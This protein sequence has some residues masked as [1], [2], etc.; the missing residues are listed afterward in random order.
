MDVAE[1]VDRDGIEQRGGQHQVVTSGD[2]P[3]HGFG[4]RANA[5]AARLMIAMRALSGV[6][7]SPQ[8]MPITYELAS[9]QRV[10][11]PTHKSLVKDIDESYL[12]TVGVDYEALAPDCV[13][14]SF[15]D[16]IDADPDGAIRC[17]CIGAIRNG[18]TTFATLSLGSA[19]VLA[20]DN[21]DWYLFC[22]NTY[23][24]TSSLR[25]GLVDVRVVCQNTHRRALA[26]KNARL[27]SV[28]HTK[29]A[30]V[31][32]ASAVDAIGAIRSEMAATRAKYQTLAGA[33][34]NGDKLDKLV[35][36]LFPVPRKE[37]AAKVAEVV[38]AAAAVDGAD[39]LDSILSATELATATVDDLID[40][41]MDAQA[42]AKR[43]ITELYE[44]KA[45]GADIPGVAGTA[46]GAYNAVTEYITHHRGRTDESRF[47]SAAMGPDT[48]RALTAVLELIKVAA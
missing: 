12:A 25:F 5:D 11:V 27:F 41:Q 34:F 4:R 40:A 7:W 13:D 33:S 10:V 37:D 20:G 36:K 44:G 35:T 39:L 9:G 30:R 45:I 16:I 8:D 32:L 28:R 21:V 24:G 46:W 38:K 15:Q 2:A 48:D 17:D 18:R 31:K 26:S 1:M 19:A 23:D 6:S 22:S 43:L 47:Q 42:K 14:D 3:W 29:N